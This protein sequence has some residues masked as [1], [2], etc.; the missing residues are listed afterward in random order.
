METRVIPPLRRGE[1]WLVHAPLPDRDAGTGTKA[2]RK[3]VVL[4]QDEQTFPAASDIAVVVA[5]TMHEADYVPEAFE[6]LVGQS[7][8]FGHL[9]VIDARWPFTMLK[10]DIRR[11]ARKAMLSARVMDQLSEAIVLGLQL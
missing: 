9:S 6:V 4:L 11:G 7:D 1:V 3:W 10:Q 2:K 8:G 5:S